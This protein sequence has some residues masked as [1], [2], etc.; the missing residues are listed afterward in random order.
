MEQALQSFEIDRAE[1]LAPASSA[2]RLAIVPTP[3]RRR[4]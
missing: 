2:L 1:L 4:S 3:R